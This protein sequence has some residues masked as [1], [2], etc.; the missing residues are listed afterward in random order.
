LLLSGKSLAAMDRPAETVAVAETRYYPPGHPWHNPSW[1]W[2]FAHPGPL[3]GEDPNCPDSFK[4]QHNL[5]RCTYGHT[6]LADRHQNGQNVAW[7]DGH[8][9]FIRWDKL[10][11]EDSAGI[12]DGRGF[13]N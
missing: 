6:L 4:V 12:W 11:A 1:G 8:A 7:A 5:A 9:K 2:Y 13:T 10:V 3:A